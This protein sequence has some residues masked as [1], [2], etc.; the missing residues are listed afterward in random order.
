M[1]S[2]IRFENYKL[3]TGDPAWNAP[4]G[5]I[6]PP[7]MDIF[8]KHEKLLFEKKVDNLGKTN[9]FQ[10]NTFDVEFVPQKKLDRMVHLYKIDTDHGKD[11]DCVSIIY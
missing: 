6:R 11:N 4:D 8:K 3:L 5:N 9:W 10:Q 2:A 7:E 1:Q